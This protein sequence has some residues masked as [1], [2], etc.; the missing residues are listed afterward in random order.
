MMLPIAADSPQQKNMI[1]IKLPLSVAAMLALAGTSLQAASIVASL[2]QSQQFNVNLTTSGDLDW[3]VW[4][5]GNSTSLTPTNRKV[6]G[7]AISALTR[8]ST[9]SSL[10]GLGQFGN[11]G[12][13][14]FSWTNGSPLANATGVFVGLQHNNSSGRI[15]EGFSF[16]V[17]ADLATRRMTLYFD[18]H[19]GISTLSATLSDGSA[20]AYSQTFNASTHNN[21]PGILTI[22]Y[23]AAS[24]GQ[25]LLISGLLTSAPDPNANFAIQAVSLAAVPEPSV[26]GLTGIAALIGLRRRRAS[27]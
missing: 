16:T 4:G 11:Y 3:A 9:G 7:S 14:S 17:P 2:V 27:R 22:D 15:N 5:Q 24:A 1:S 26:L 6:G 12:A 19:L 21:W 8:V 20:T 18:T 25:T 10:R 23:S 13:S